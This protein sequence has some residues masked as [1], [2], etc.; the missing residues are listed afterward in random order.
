MW[1]HQLTQGSLT[2]DSLTPDSDT[3]E[4][5]PS[6]TCVV[7]PEPELALL[8]LVVDMIREAHHRQE[9]EVEEEQN[10]LEMMM[11]MMMSRCDALCFQQY[12]LY[13]SLH[14]L[15]QHR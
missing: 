13:T 3:S 7:R 11:V 2:P 10:L 5:Y 8:S 12:P 4:L 14:T 6:E 1:F 15:Y 9:E